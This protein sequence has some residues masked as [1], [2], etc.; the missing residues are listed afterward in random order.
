MNLEVKVDMGKVSANIGELVPKAQKALEIVGQT[1]GAKMKSYAQNNAK[2]T[3]RTGAARGGLDF[4]S[5][6]EGTVLTISIMHTVDYGLWLEIRDFPHAGRL[7]I[8]EEARDSQV[9][10]FLNMVKKIL[11]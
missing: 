6:W 7:A 11:G 1:T 5:R 2:W 8:L 3:D 10:S 4:N 9:Q